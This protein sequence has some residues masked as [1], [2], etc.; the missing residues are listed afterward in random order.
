[1]N[2]S[3]E[4]DATTGFIQFMSYANLLHRVDFLNIID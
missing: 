2:S 3:A 4:F 1:M